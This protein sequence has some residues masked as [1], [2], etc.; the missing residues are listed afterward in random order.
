MKL[1]MRR[2]R[3]GIVRWLHGAPRRRSGGSVGHVRATVKADRRADITPEAPG[4]AAAGVC[5]PR[6]SDRDDDE[7]PLQ[8]GVAAEAPSP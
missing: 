2:S 4:F 7:D 8:R 1:E 6:R 3:D 5:D